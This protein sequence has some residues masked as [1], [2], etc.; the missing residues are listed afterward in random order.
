MDEQIVARILV[1]LPPKSVYRFRAVSKSW[2]DL[3]SHPFFIQRYGR[4]QRPGGGLGMLFGFCDSTLP[5]LSSQ[6]PKSNLKSV[7]KILPLDIPSGRIIECKPQEQKLGLFINSSNGL[8]LCCDTHYQPDTR[9]LGEFRVVNPFTK[10]S[11]SLP[12]PPSLPVNRY[13][14]IGLM[15]EDNESELSAKYIVI[16]TDCLFVQREKDSLRIV[17]YSSNTGLWAPTKPKVITTGD[18]HSVFLK[19]PLVMNS[20]FHW[21]IYSDKLT[22][23]LYRP[24]PEEVIHIRGY[25][26]IIN[27]NH[28][29]SAMTRSSIDDGDTLWFGCMEHETMRV[30]MLQN[31][32]ED[33]RSIV[34][35]NQE[36][37]LKYVISRDCFWSELVLL[38]APGI[39]L[40]GLLPIKNKKA[41]VALIRFQ[42]H[43]QG[44]V[45]LY[46]L[47]TDSLQSV[48][49]HGPSPTSEHW[50]GYHY[51]KN[52]RAVYPYLE[53]SFL[54]SFAL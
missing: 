13:V 31:G 6:H 38:S 9:L 53:A 28:T 52:F 37:V 39:F 15:C 41:P 26:G 8:I 45:F 3:I 7:I 36:W 42:G 47:D 19:F 18:P 23:A 21:Y 40:E 22:L 10:R 14:S 43:I 25:D 48:P 35:S 11:V 50:N 16:R 30:F 54:S 20:V 27:D 33:G 49:Y 2:N 51:I 1:C 34:L 5:S 12:P 17:T 29:F 46:N 44:M 4:Q 32:N 24:G